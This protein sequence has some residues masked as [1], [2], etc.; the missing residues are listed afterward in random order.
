MWVAEQRS[1]M[2]ADSFSLSLS[3]SAGA[4]HFTMR[5]ESEANE[6]KKNKTTI[7]KGFDAIRRSDF[8]VA[9]HKRAVN[10][11]HLKRDDERRTSVNDERWSFNSLL[12]IRAPAVPTQADQPLKKR[13]L[14]R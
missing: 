2:E 5:S 4:F 14:K 8:C 1:Q 3:L 12:Y 7:T 9:A 6:K 10:G 11:I 13:Y